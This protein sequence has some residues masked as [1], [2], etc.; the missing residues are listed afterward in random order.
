MSH[1]LKTIAWTHLLDPE[2]QQT[3]KVSLQVDTLD[4]L[5]W[6]GRKAIKSKAHKSQA[7]SGAILVK[8]ERNK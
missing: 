5:T 6:L 1:D 4:I 3:Y 8:A 2:T 7:L